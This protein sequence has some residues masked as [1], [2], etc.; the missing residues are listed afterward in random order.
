MPAAMPMGEQGTDLHPTAQ[1]GHAGAQR[2]PQLQL[3]TAFQ[4]CLISPWGSVPRAGRGT[5]PDSAFC[6]V[7]AG[8]LTSRLLGQKRSRAEGSPAEGLSLPAFLGQHPQLGAV[9]LAELGA[10]TTG[11]PRLRPAL[12]AVLTLLAQLQP[13]PDGPDR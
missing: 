11:G 13:G 7:P 6:P 1:W 9:L 3:G 4:G 10:A 5:G 2:V 12:H 8:A